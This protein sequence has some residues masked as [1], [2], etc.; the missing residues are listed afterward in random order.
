MA[1]QGNPIERTWAKIDLILADAK[2][3]RRKLGEHALELQSLYSNKSSDVRR[4][5]VGTFE[6][7]LGKRELKPGTVR[8]WIRDYRAFQSGAPSSAAKRKAL[9]H[10][11]AQ[12]KT[13]ADYKRG[14][15]DGYRAALEESS[16]K[17]DGHNRHERAIQ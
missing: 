2:S 16:K 8:E 5:G 1:E 13:S 17:V 15:Q 4:L 3:D 14:Y 9:R 12:D 11:A 7:E 10:R 6:Q